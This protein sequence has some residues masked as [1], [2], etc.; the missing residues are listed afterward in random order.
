MTYQAPHF[1]VINQATVHYLE[2]RIFNFFYQF[3]VAERT[4][5]DAVSVENYYHVLCAQL[6]PIYVYYIVLFF[7]K[8]L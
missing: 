3:I 7:S 4:K 6:S 8:R 5:E 1:R 2:F